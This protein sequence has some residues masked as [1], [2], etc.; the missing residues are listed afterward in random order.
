M[1][2][3][4]SLV[5]IGVFGIAVTALADD[6]EDT[7]SERQ[8]TYA[9]PYLEDDAMKPR[10]GTTRGP[11]LTLDTTPGEQWLALQAPELS[12]QERDRRAIL[13]MAGGY[14]ASFDFI[15]TVGFV[16]DYVP[17]RPYQSWGTE[18]VYVVE[19]RADFISLQHI[20]VMTFLNDND[21]L[22]GPMVVKHWRQDWQYEDTELHVYTGHNTWER[23]ELT[24]DQAAGTWSQSVFQVD[25]SP[26][27]Q[28]I[29]RWQHDANYSSWLSDETWRPLPRREFSVRDDYHALVGT[30]RH[31]ITP[32]GWV[33]EEDNL[34]VVLDDNGELAGETPYL[35]REAGFNRYERVLDHD[36][37]AGDDYWEL[38][39]PFW[40]DVR[41]AWTALFAEQGSLTLMDSY[42]DQSLF[43][44]MFMFAGNISDENPYDADAGRSF[45]DQTLSDFLAN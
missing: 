43:M 11:A 15:E 37:T 39:Q 23:V 28:A 4:A 20:L 21:E 45:I 24:A 36:F 32:T 13:A 41:A 16:P 3:L 6:Q 40:S 12:T 22:V 14:R 35:A 7:T 27:Y 19:D 29:G 18:Y 10:G 25:D 34:K 30:N 1:A 26:R 44:T 42:N 5:A 33:H 8:F 9:W 31:T 17:K 38:T 2:K